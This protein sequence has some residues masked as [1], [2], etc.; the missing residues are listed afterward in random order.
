MESLFCLYSFRIAA[1]SY[2]TE[3]ELTRH[4]LEL[5]SKTEA[6]APSPERRLEAIARLRKEGLFADILLM[7]VLP[8]LEDS[9]ENVTGIIE[10]AHEAYKGNYGYG[11]LSLFDL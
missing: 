6:Y 10:A 7:P 1:V 9:E 8:F 4:A 11:Q 5:A 3:M 2:L